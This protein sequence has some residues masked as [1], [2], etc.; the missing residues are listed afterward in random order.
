MVYKL[1]STLQLDD[2]TGSINVVCPAAAATPGVELASSASESVLA[3]AHSPRGAISLQE[4]SLPCGSMPNS[5]PSP[6]SC[7]AV[8][9]LQETVRKGD[10]VLVVGKLQARGEG[11]SLKA[12]KVGA[13]PSMPSFTVR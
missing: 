12:H 5:K 7:L 4:P 9:R 11:L 8:G 3:H 2:G 6:P 13:A 1:T 10:Y